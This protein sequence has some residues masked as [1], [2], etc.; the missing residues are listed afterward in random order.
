VVRYERERRV[1]WL[2]HEDRSG[3]GAVVSLTAPRLGAAIDRVA[4]RGASCRVGALLV[5]ESA[6]GQLWARVMLAHIALR[7]RDSDRD[8]ARGE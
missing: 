8:A 7:V 3:N 1:H 4:I 6:R 5:I 2:R